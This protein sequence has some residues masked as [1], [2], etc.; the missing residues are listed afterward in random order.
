[1]NGETHVTVG[2]AATTTLMAV[3]VIEPAIVP[4]A[5]AAIASLLPDIDHDKATINARL[6]I[7]K[8]AY[9][10]AAGVLLYYSQDVKTIIISL[11]LIAIGFSKHRAITHSLLAVVMVYLAMKFT[12]VQNSIMVAAM[13]GYVSHLASDFF[14]NKGIE[15][16]FPHPKRIKFPITITTGGAIEWVISS[17]ASV[18]IIY[19]VIRILPGIHIF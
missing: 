13:I 11:A 15:L 2:V 7:N 17:L 19:N 18:L 4:L 12:G 5:A 1:M 10:L 16:F 3:G 6:G 8:T 9:V 14:T